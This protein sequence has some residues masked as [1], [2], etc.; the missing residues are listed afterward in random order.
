MASSG[1]G[2]LE[3]AMLNKISVSLIDR[4][5]NQKAVKRMLHSKPLILVLDE[6]DMMF[7]KNSHG[8]IAETWFQT[9]ISWTQN[10]KMRFSMIGISNS[11][12]DENAHLVRKLASVSCSNLHSCFRR[13]KALNA[14]LRRRN[15]ASSSFLP[16][17]KR[18]S[19]RSCRPALA[20]ESST[21]RLSS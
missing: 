14:L 1:E 7:N 16:T 4:K 19:S 15:P 17:K 13:D 10:K 18:T 6:I 5:S 2:G 21:P 3:E 12:N 8:G 11:V 20:P 9:L